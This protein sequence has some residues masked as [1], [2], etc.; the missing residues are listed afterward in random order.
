M[1]PHLVPRS[2]PA[3]YVSPKFIRSHP[4]PVE[5][6]D[7]HGFP[8][9]WRALLEIESWSSLT[10]NGHLLR[11]SIKCLAHGQVSYHKNKKDASNLKTAQSSTRQQT[12]GMNDISWMGIHP[13]PN[14]HNT[15]RTRLHWTE[16]LSN[17]FILRWPLYRSWWVRGRTMHYDKRS[18]RIGV[19]GEVPVGKNGTPMNGHHCYCYF[20]VICTV[21]I[22]G[23]PGTMVV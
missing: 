12:M 23:C 17:L 13:P 20:C 1:R 15:S 19:I 8:A 14:D 21:K 5:N 2:R 7:P 22:L 4:L 11:H 9:P 3:P 6:P 18:V 16:S 10:F